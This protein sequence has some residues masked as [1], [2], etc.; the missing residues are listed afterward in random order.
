MRQKGKHFCDNCWEF[1]KKL[2]PAVH[3][4]ESDP[5]NHEINDDDTPVD[6]CED[7]YEASYMDI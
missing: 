4:Q 7:C 5:Y 2:T 6:L 1:Y 3:I